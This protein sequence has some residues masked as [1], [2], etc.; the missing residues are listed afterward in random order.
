MRK[1]RQR[2]S[3][4]LWLTLLLAGLA[5]WLLIARGPAPNRVP[6]TAHVSEWTIPGE[7]VLDLRDDAPPTAMN[8]LAARFNLQLAVSH[9]EASPGRIHV[10]RVGAG[11]L[12]ETLESL[13][14]HPMVAAAE[15]QRIFRIPPMEAVHAGAGSGRSLSSPP[16]GKGWKP[17]DP[18][19]SEQWN[20]HRLGMEQAWQATRGKGAVVAVIDTGVAFEQDQKC[21]LARDFGKTKFV[22][23]YDFVFRDRHPNDDNGHGTHVAGTI[24]ESTNNGE[25]VAGIAFEAT[26]MPLKV[27][28][29]EGMGR[30]SDVAAAIRYAADNGAHVINLSLGSPLPDAIT[31]RAC[32]YALRKG[33]TIVAAAGNT[34]EEG[35]SYPAAYPGVI[36]VSALGPSGTLAPY[37]SWGA[38]IALCAPGG[39]K[40]AGPEGGILQ[41][42]IL[43]GNDDY[44]A[45]QGT[46][47]ATPHVAAVAAL[48][49]S[50]GVRDPAE[51]RTVLEQSAVRRGPAEKYGAGEVNAANAVGKARLSAAEY[52]TR[53]W[54]VG[55]I[56]FWYALASRARRLRGARAS[57]AAPLAVTIGLYLPDVVL[58]FAGAGSPWNLLG[59]GVVVPALLYWWEAESAAEKRFLGL[60]SAGAALHLAWD[61][62]Q[63]TAPPMGVG[64]GAVIWL[65][66]NTLIGMGVLFSSLRARR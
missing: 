45:F 65:W 36:A 49:V 47:M 38:P 42:T 52:R 60:V 2:I 12:A 35:V 31:R 15:P 25:G 61:L 6:S 4:R 63:G 34:G 37:S 22:E 13:R 50:Q 19:Y 64:G 56:W 39:D 11:A 16:V 59:H 54:L 48:I 7:I 10:A 20:L 33:V 30:M 44:Y 3:S 21:R 1:R 8:S 43:D 57:M 24:A 32:E 58:A 62:L 51:V 18:R 66:A 46:S 28:T 26:I 29:S 27:L 9:Q 41:N 55:A 53:L 14:R 40:T 17:N 5:A 23:P